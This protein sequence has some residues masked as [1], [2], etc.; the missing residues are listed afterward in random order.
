MDALSEEAYQAQSDG[1]MAKAVLAMEKVLA[2]DP[3]HPTANFVLGINDINTLLLNSETRADINRV[4]ALV[5]DQR[6]LFD[7]SGGQSVLLGVDQALVGVVNNV[8]FVTSTQNMVLQDVFQKLEAHMPVMNAAIVRLQRVLRHSQL[9]Y[10][11]VSDTFALDYRLNRLDVLGLYAGL[12]LVRSLLDM[13][14]SYDYRF[15]E[16]QYVSTEDWL[17]KNPN[18]LTLRPDGVRRMANAGMGLRNAITAVIAAKEEA[19]RSP[20]LGRIS[21]ADLAHAIPVLEDIRRSLKGETVR[22]PF[23]VINNAKTERVEHTLAVNLGN[24]FNSP[25]SD[26]RHYLGVHMKGPLNASSF[27][28]GFDFTLGELFPELKAYADWQTYNSFGLVL[29]NDDGAMGDGSLNAYSGTIKKSGDV[30]VVLGG[31]AY[32]D[33]SVAEVFRVSDH[34]AVGSLGK[35][36]G[37]GSSG[38]WRD[39]HTIA[40]SAQWLYH[41]NTAKLSVYS[42]DGSAIA[43]VHSLSLSSSALDMHVYQDRLYVITASGIDRYSLADPTRPT[44]LGSTGFEYSLSG[45]DQIS[46]KDGK[47]AFLK[48]VWG[49]SNSNGYFYTTTVAQYDLA[50]G[51]RTSVAT[52]Q[53]G[54]YGYGQYVNGTFVAVLSRK[55]YSGYDIHWSSGE[56]AVVAGEFAG[57][58]FNDGFLGVGRYSSNI[59][60]DVYDLRT[61]GTAKHVGDYKPFSGGNPEILLPTEVGVWIYNS[62][63]QLQF[64]GY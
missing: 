32:G 22:V 38:Y 58:A 27:P 36:A 53:T 15:K 40:L 5:T 4:I 25:I 23:S 63:Q 7:T 50:S 30:L 47:M 37:T 64:V 19:D 3:T 11:V 60:F 48:R 6:A 13:G 1:D 8:L 31:D 55:D 28:T 56:T 16:G 57:V 54:Y 52:Y 14:L 46:F 35:I 44:F 42:T 26:F 24:F 34:T 29:Y 9:D 10:H 21:G 17:S 61:P 2:I 12:N 59:G 49:F 62:K 33:R 18:F 41:A 39:R 43:K 20:H 45:Y 51:E